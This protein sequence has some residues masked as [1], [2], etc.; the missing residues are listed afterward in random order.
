MMTAASPKTT[1]IASSV[2]DGAAACRHR[3]ASRG[4][5][6]ATAPRPRP[7][8]TRG[9]RA[10]GEEARRRGAAPAGAAARVTP[11]RRWPTA[12]TSGSARGSARRTGSGASA[13][14]T[15]I[16]P[17]ATTPAT[18]AAT[19]GPAPEVLDHVG[20]AEPVGVPHEVDGG[21][22][23]DHDHGEHAAEDRGGVDPAV[24]G[25]PASPP[26]GTRPEAIAAGDRAHAV[27]ARAP[28]RWRRRR[29]SCGGRGCGTRPCGRRSSRRAARCR[30]AAMVSGHEQG[31]RDRGDT[32]PG[33][34]VHSTTK[35][36]ISHTWL[37]S[38]TGPIE[39]SISSRGRSP[40]SGAAG[41]QVPE[42]GAE[43]GAAEHGVRGDADEQHDRD[44]GRSSAAASSRRPRLG[45]RAA[46]RSAR[47]GTS[48]V[49]E[50]AGVRR[51]RRLI[52]RS[53]RIVGDAERRRR[54]RR[55][56]RT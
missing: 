29:R 19:D 11:C 13:R 1:R 12:M 14:S 16:P 50:P 55:P 17:N 36:K 15:K 18:T 33:T 9:H 32:P 22:V 3:H 48:V 4:A 40:R 27:R 2:P 41:Q 8:T 54:A 21:E 35:Q 38:H 44:G 47:T 49:V 42:P 51:N 37:A 7:T 23:G 53:T 56:R 24:H 25:S 5:R 20:V 43:V 10:D 45:A 52:P 30:S 31:E 26:A 28:T 6:S 34:P 46:A 39:W